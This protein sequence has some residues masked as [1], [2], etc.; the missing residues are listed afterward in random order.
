MADLHGPS[1]FAFCR[2]EA[3]LRL[4]WD[5]AYV[6]ADGRLSLEQLIEGMIGGRAVDPALRR[7]PKI[8]EMFADLHAGRRRLI[9]DGDPNYLCYGVGLDVPLGLLRGTFVFVAE[10]EAGAYLCAWEPG[11]GEV[12]WRFYR[13]RFA[14]VLPPDPEPGP[15]PGPREY[16]E[17]GPAVRAA[18]ERHRAELEAMPS[19]RAR[20][21]FLVEKTGCSLSYAFEILVDEGL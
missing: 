5:R 21:R 2:A 15:P 12:G 3:D 6:G 17:L 13:P 20:G 9:A 18:L 19:R 7:P 10:N 14:P 1:L 8:V 4:E 11:V 16:G